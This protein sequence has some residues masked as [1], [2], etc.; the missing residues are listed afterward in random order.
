MPYV[1]E[2][3]GGSYLLGTFY[4]DANFPYHILGMDEE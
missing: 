3:S 4:I 2:G 1:G